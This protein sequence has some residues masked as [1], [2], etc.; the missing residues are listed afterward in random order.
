MPQFQKGDRVVYQADPDYGYFNRSYDGKTGTI[1]SERPDGWGRLRADWDD[2]GMRGVTPYPVNLQ[3]LLAPVV[4][5][6]TPTTAYEVDSHHD[7]IAHPSHYTDGRKYEPKDVIRDWG[8]AFNLGAVV[9]YVA[10]A[11][12]KAD[13]PTLK[14][15]R[16]ARQFLDFEIEALEAEAAK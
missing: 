14:D 10:R 7:D 13:T 16:K 2:P 4:A 11:G 5:I 1:T 15:L 9:K 8:L 3:H 6:D 12:R